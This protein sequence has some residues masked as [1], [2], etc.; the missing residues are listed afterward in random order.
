M[1]TKKEKALWILYGVV[2]FLLFLLSSTNL[3]IK[4]KERRIYGI[5]VIIEDTSDDNYVN[6]RKGMDRAAMELY[7]DV[8]FITLYDKGSV[9]QQE[10]LILRE[11]QD[12]C[13]A[14]IVAPVDAKRVLEMQEDKRIN[15][16]LILLNSEIGSG[17]DGITERIGF[18]Y[19]QMGQDLGKQ[20]L[21]DS[22]FEGKIRRKAFLFGET[23]PVSIQFRDGILDQLKPEGVE[24][25]L[26]EGSEASLKEALEGKQGEQMVLIALDPVSLTE[27]AQL[28]LDMGTEN[29]SPGLYGRGTA[30]R[31]L[32]Y[33]DKGV[34]Q[35][36]CITDDFSAGYLSVKMAVELAENQIVE[37]LG[38]LE[39]RCIRRE[40]L[41][42][43]EF[44]KMLYPIE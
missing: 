7:G 23:D 27:M 24:I 9:K 16:P 19:Y 12:G 33:L 35:G 11:Q 39:S 44:E 4:E 21:E 26:W 30:V 14:L 37:D 8:S 5:S 29:K 6:F 22:V 34:I 1:I 25:V 13:K 20:I 31:L 42:D 40:D 10:E 15:V 43:V 38:Y 2:L 41:R 36:L 32:N 3:I 28:L 18:D 17:G